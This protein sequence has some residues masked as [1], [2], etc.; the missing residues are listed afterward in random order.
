MGYWI[1]PTKALSVSEVMG[2]QPFPGV[3]TS[4]EP[5]TKTRRHLGARLNVFVNDRFSFALDA[6]LAAR[7]GIAPGDVLDGETLAE[8]LHEDGAA[9]AYAGALNFLSFRVR[10]AKEVRARLERDEWP[11]E[12]IDS[13]LMRLQQERLL[14]DAQ[15]AT[16]WVENRSLFRPRGAGMLRQE[17]RQKGVEKSE[18]EA[19]LPDI[20][21]EAEN[22]LAA[23]RS[24]LRSF[25]RY[26]PK[27]QRE[28]ALGFLQ[29]RG[30]NFSVARAAWEKLQEEEGL[31]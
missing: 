9:K 14:D 2:K 26:E 5:Q 22:A 4:L 12:V 7:R 17:L 25:E 29:R 8:L 10:S 31:T 3:I 1:L 23:L 19:A 24:K 11:N 21:E 16:M 15:F 18:I 30:F 13:V 6:S 28:K 27:E 20:D